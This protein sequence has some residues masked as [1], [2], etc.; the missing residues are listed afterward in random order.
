MAANSTADADISFTFLMV[1]SKVGQTRLHNF[2]IAELMI[3]KP[4]T[5]EQH[6]NQ[7]TNHKL[8][9]EIFFMKNTIF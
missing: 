2:S 1:R 4:N 9:L 7:Q 3:S 8:N 6:N 5:T